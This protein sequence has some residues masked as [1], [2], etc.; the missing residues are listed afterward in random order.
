MFR[1]VTRACPTAGIALGLGLLLAACVIE[2]EPAQRRPL[3][4]DVMRAGPQRVEAGAPVDA[5]REGDPVV[6]LPAA[7]A[8]PEAF[9]ACK[10]DADCV[11]VLPNG[12]CHDGRNEAINKASA[13]AYKA[14]F[15]C[16]IARPRC[17]MHLILDRREPA[18]DTATHACALVTPSVP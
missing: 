5:P 13:D 4:R 12:C 6:V 8:M 3:L 18:C 17:P 2:T 7:P 9:R 10:S 1:R 15:T 16:P 14:S 11:T